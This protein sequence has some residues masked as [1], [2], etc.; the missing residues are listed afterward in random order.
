M[1]SLALRRLLR[2]TPRPVLVS[3]PQVCPPK[4]WRGG[5]REWLTGIPDSE[6]AEPT[7][8]ASLPARRGSS[9]DAVRFEFMA[10]LDDVPGRHAGNVIVQIDRALSMHELWHLRLDIF[11]LVSCHH[12]QAEADQRLAQLNRHFPTRAPRSGFGALTQQVTGA[13]AGPAL[14]VSASRAP[15]SN[16]GR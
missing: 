5:W 7:L 3:H 6:F 11:N 16:R 8:A 10:A 1:F 12:D 2:P 13:E 9:L 15:A 4:L 14:A